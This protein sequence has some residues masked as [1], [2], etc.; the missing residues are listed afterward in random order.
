MWIAGEGRDGD[1][2]SGVQRPAGECR[3][4]FSC[5]WPF[6]TYFSCE[7]IT[8]NALNRPRDHENAGKGSKEPSY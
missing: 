4:L 7:L 3:V 1:C 8:G 5:I 2:R 6:F